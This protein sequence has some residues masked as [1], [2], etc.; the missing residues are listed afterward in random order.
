MGVTRS[1]LIVVVA[2]LFALG[3]ALLVGKVF[4][5]RPPAAPVVASAPANPMAQVLVAQHDLV[6][7]E[8]LHEGDLAWHAWPLD[9][10]N[11][12]FITDG[13]P[14]QVAT[15]GASATV[16]KTVVRAA[17]GVVAPGPMETLYGAIVREPISANEPVTNAK[18]VRGG[19]G[20]FMA[21]VLRPGMRAVAVPVNASTGAGGF[22][23]PGDHVDVL[24]SH[25]AEGSEASSMLF[26][27]Q[28]GQ[29]AQVL[30]RNV[31]VLAID[32]NSK[33]PK[34]TSSVIGAV[35]TLEVPAS[36]ADVLVRAKAQGEIILAL[37]AYSD[38]R[39]PTGRSQSEDTTAGVVRIFRDGKATEVM[40]T[41]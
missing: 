30:L 5:H 29:I 18:L 36:D 11:P 17:S 31:R 21:V 6:V 9:A 4:V 27:S 7:G 34:N 8:A 41:R 38:A 15:K 28:G 13:R 1:I 19:A 37:R 22:I 10:L 25:H 12:A 3:A 33:P 32:Q 24:Q 23:L 20:G 26:A 16:V 40:V 39:G 35:A 14:P 2:A